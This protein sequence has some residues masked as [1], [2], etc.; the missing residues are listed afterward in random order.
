MEDGSVEEA[1]VMRYLLGD[2]PEET[3]VQVED[4][5][6]ADRRVPLLGL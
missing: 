4:R 6:F 3:L 2:L 5:A 1:V